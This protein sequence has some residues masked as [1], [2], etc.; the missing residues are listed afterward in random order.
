MAHKMI[1]CDAEGVRVHCEIGEVSMM[2]LGWHVFPR[3]MRSS[4]CGWLHRMPKIADFWLEEVCEKDVPWLDVK[5]G[6]V[7]EIVNVFESK[8]ASH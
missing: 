4:H 1:H 2:Q 8:K 6:L 5:M 7:N 3:S